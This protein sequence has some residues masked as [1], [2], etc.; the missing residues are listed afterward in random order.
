MDRIKPED[1]L[2]PDS[3]DRRPMHMHQRVIGSR[4]SVSRQCL[5]ISIGILLLL[6]LVIGMGLALKTPPKYDIAQQSLK[7]VASKDMNLSS[8]SSST[9]VQGTNNMVDGS[10]DACG[11][12]GVKIIS[13]PQSITIPSVSSPVSQDQ[14]LS[15]SGISH[16]NTQ[17]PGHITDTL[18]SKPSQFNAVRPGKTATQ[19]M[20]TKA[21]TTTINSATTKETMRPLQGGA[22]QVKPTN[23]PA[24]MHHKLSTT[25]SFS[26]KVG[27]TNGTVMRTIVKNYYT[28]QLSSATRPD[29]LY[30]YA[31][32]QRLKHYLV[33]S[34]QRN[35]KPW[36]ILVS[37]HYSSSKEAKHAIVTLPLDVQAKKP[38][39]RPAYKA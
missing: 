14:R 5:I 19:V 3:S 16:Q 20:S 30:A 33:Y 18:H 8:S 24:I 22:P 34:T 38:W 27:T 21:S 12:N 11:N 26:K 2:R 23:Q 32:R 15:P 7:N 28:L 6:L 31:K 29:T 17:L 13:Q 1:D 35:A 25:G 36:Y 4:F 9:S 39:V 10:M 37:G